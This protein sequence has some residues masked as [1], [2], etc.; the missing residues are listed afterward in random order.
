MDFPMHE[1]EI[2]VWMLGSIVLGF[3]VMYRTELRRLPASGWLFAAYVA[4]WLA[5]SATNLEHV[6][7]YRFFNIAEH[8][9]YALNGVLLLCWCWFAFRHG[10]PE[11]HAYD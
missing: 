10:N 2:L 8:M 6:L 1:N 3:L 4:A 5:W 11:P 7:L 9:A